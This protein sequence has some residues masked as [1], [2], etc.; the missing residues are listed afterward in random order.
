MRAKFKNQ[1]HFAAVFLF[2]V[3]YNIIPFFSLKKI[4]LRLFGIKIGKESFIH[5]PAKFFSFRNMQIGDN[6]TI[7]PH[8]YLDARSGIR[9]GSNVNIANNTRIY[10]LGHDIN[11]PDLRLIGAGVDIGDEAFIFSNV[12]ILPGVKIGKGAVVYAGS[13][14]VKDV[15]P[16]TVV[17]GNPAKFIKNREKVEFEKTIYGYWFAQ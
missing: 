1:I 14:V 11:A 15:E 2:N 13:V 16:Y 6:T 4:L 3:L 8:C 12:L 7:N 17:G 10:T 5:I 9:I